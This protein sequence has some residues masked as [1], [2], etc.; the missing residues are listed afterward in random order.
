MALLDD[1]QLAGAM[2]QWETLVADDRKA[3]VDVQRE[4]DE[5]LSDLTHD[6]R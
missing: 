6:S 4:W 3:F 1:D 2:Q 5:L